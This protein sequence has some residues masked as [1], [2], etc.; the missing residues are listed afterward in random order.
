MAIGVH[1]VVE[2]RRFVAAYADRLA[3]P[4][5]ALLALPDETLVTLLRVIYGDYYLPYPYGDN[6]GDG[7]FLLVDTFLRMISRHFRKR[8]AGEVLREG[9][10]TTQERER[11]AER[12]QKIVMRGERGDDIFAG[13]AESPSRLPGTALSIC[14]V[15]F[16]LLELIDATPYVRDTIAPEGKDEV[17]RLSE[18]TVVAHELLCEELP[19]PKLDDIAALITIL[20]GARGKAIER[21]MPPGSEAVLTDADI[22]VFIKMILV[23]VSGGRLE[24]LREFAAA[25]FEMIQNFTHVVDRAYANARCKYFIPGTSIVYFAREVYM[26][27]VRYVGEMLVDRAALDTFRAVFSTDAAAGSPGAR[28]SAF[29]GAAGAGGGAAAAARIDD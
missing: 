15:L 16:K 29:L 18:L 7:S 8:D 24:T 11:V 22:D 4:K 20:E 25:P 12:Y 28:A 2:A 5:R 14:D 1:G 13:P 10:L 26:D 23:R 17:N 21:K 6:L 27:L 9:D 19:L 3:L